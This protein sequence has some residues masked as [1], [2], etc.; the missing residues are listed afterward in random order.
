MENKPTK[1]GKIMILAIVIGIAAGAAVGGVLGYFGRC[2]SGTC[3]LTSN[4]YTGAIFGAVMGGV[5][6]AMIRS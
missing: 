6:A 5:I 1:R 2:S 4:P 3:P